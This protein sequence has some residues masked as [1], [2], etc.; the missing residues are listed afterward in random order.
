MAELSGTLS[1][2]G[3]GPGIQGTF[4][5]PYLVRL[6]VA[7]QPTV[8]SIRM[9]IAEVGRVQIGRG[10]IFDHH[11]EHDADG[12]AL[13]VAVPDSW[14]SS[15]HAELLC[16]EEQKWRLRDCG[17]KN[18]SYLNGARCEESPLSDGDL[19]HTGNTTFLF[20]CLVE[21]SHLDPADVDAADLQA[22]P[23]AAQTLSLPLA[24][25]MKDLALVATSNVSVILGGETGTGKEVSARYLHEASRRSGAFVAVNCGA[26]PANLV[27][28]ELFGHRK[29]AFSGAQS[30]RVGLVQASDGGT[31]FLDEVAELPLE[32]QVKLLRVLQEREIVPV[33]ATRPIPVDLRVVAASHADLEAL[34]E[35]GTFRSDLYARLSGVSFR[36]PPLRER[37]EDLG[38]LVSL[39]LRRAAPERSFTFE[40]EALWAIAL[41]SWPRNIREL[42]Q[43]LAAAVAWAEDGVIRLKNLPP[44]VVATL[45]GES[46]TEEDALASQ[47]KR[48]LRTHQGNVS[49][50]ARE[51][52]KARVQIRRWCKRFGINPAD[53]R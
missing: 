42:E 41:Y 28:S 48:A 34:V 4:V 19:I 44:A 12:A 30:D 50:T 49:A 46:A 24:H 27:E 43:A 16:D 14:M 52:G 29:G 1:Y 18:G 36:L 5:A 33:G 2:A 39:L 11:R 7:D 15:K 20:R 22:R 40:R 6:S 21:R 25:I 9:S 35:A 51:M 31:L 37:R 26:L 32:A 45:G 13:Q 47:L 8:A 53:Y 10:E 23:T 17:S 3:D 38:I